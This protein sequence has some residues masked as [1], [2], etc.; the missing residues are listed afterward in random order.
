MGGKAMEAIMSELRLFIT[1]AVFEQVEN[2]TEE[3]RRAALRT[4]YFITKKGM[5]G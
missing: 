2:P 3:Q 5:E 4:H 1:E